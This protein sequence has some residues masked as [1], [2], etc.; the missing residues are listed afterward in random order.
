MG[1]VVKSPAGEVPV[2]S[3]GFGG[4]PRLDGEDPDHVRLLAETC[5]EL[6]PILVHRPTMQVIDGRHRLRAAILRGAERIAVMFFDGDERAAFILGVRANITH[7]RPLSLADR[8]EAAARVFELHPEWSDRAVARCVGLSPDTV[9]NVRRRST[10]DSGQMNVRL[11]RD[12]RVRPLDSSQGR[13]RAGEILTAR[14]SASLREVAREAGIAVGTVRDVRERIR[15]G[16]DVL[17]E[18]ANTAGRNA[19]PPV[20]AEKKGRVEA[21]DVTSM[22]QSLRRDPSLRFTEAGRRLLRWLD[23]HTVSQVEEAWLITA[24]PPHC[25]NVVAELVRAD[26]LARHELA[27]A[28]E[29]RADQ[30]SIG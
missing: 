26:A 19:V 3:L 13:L 29:Q 9:G 1:P 27:E 25:A 10:V 18:R 16:A 4:S 21:E 2:E 5:D 15:R 14:P 22:L 8:R 11:G 28:I 6:P 20:K 17:P 7:G 12:G 24:V 30:A 23:Q